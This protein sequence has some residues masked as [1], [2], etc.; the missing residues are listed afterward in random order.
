MTDYDD[1]GPVMKELCMAA[2]KTFIYLSYGEFDGL[3][4]PAVAELYVLR[5]L[6]D[7][8]IAEQREAERNRSN[9]T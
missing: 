1:A 5:G 7:G 9:Q 6:I 4:V 8:A 3:R 2:K